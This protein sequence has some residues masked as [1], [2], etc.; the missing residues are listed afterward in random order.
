MTDE[1][2]VEVLALLRD[3]EHKMKLERGIVSVRLV[4]LGVERSALL[5]ELF[6]EKP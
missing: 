2:R 3:I 5:S 1:R 4:E 6:D